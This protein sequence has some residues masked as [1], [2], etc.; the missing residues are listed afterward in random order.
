M[1]ITWEA[2]IDR[3]TVTGI[4]LVVTLRMRLKASHNAFGRAIQR[5]LSDP[6]E[7]F[8]L[9]KADRHINATSRILYQPQRPR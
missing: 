9:P 2:E 3:K 7:T 6:E 4:V 5:W 8:D 1:V